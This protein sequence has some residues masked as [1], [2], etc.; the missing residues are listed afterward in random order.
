MESPDFSQYTHDQLR[1]ILT[2][3]NRERYPERAAEI[4][5]RLAEPEPEPV[6]PDSVAAGAAAHRP[7]WAGF[8]RRTGAFAIDM[9]LLALTGAALG[10]FFGDALQALGAWGRLLGLG[11]ALAYFVLLESRGGRGQTPGKALLGIAVR[12][13]AGGRLRPAVAAGRALVWAIPF[14]LNQAPLPLAPDNIP[15]YAILSLLVFGLGAANG[16]LLVVDR[17]ARRSL[18]DRLFGT[19]MVR[20]E[21]DADGL[22]PAMPPIW[23]GHRWVVAG[24]LL[25]SLTAPLVMMKLVSVVRP[26]GPLL[27]TQAR[28]QELPGVR[29]AS[30]MQTTSLNQSR[31]NGALSISLVM[32]HRRE[33]EPL[34]LARRAARIALQAYPDAQRL[35]MI[36]VTIATGYDIGLWSQWRSH[37]WRAAPAQWLATDTPPAAPGVR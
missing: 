37:S 34:A 7:A 36:A 19:V 33:P 28:L 22:P 32:A 16:Y 3:L 5:R 15:A 2:R 1:Q 6:T 21:A 18:A 13:A 23:R 30:V 17:P 35:D 29:A 27:A 10:L 14:F 24:I 26:L 8:W 9:A 20:A 25:L 12:D 31:P 11:M 4:E